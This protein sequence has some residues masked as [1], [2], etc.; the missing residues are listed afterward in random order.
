MR[1]PC[2]VQCSCTAGSSGGNVRTRNWLLWLLPLGTAC[3][4]GLE[5]EDLGTE[6]EA[7]TTTCGGNQQTY[8]DLYKPPPGS[9][10]ACC[11]PYGP[12]YFS[13]C[14]PSGTLCC[15]GTET[16]QIHCCDSTRYCRIRVN[17]P[18]L[19]DAQC[20]VAI[21]GGQPFNGLTQ[22][23]APRGV[24]VAKKPIA[25]LADC[26]DRI[27][28]PGFDAVPN[29]CGTVEKRLP[30]HFGPANFTPQCNAHDICYVTCP[31]PKRKCD[32]ALLKGI[33][34]T[35]DAAF[36]NLSQLL[37]KVTCEHVAFLAAK[38]AVESPIGVLAYDSAQ[39]RGCQCCL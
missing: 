30:D 28:T 3:G 36:T 12:L 4:V 27:S 2:G 5:K 17:Q 25:S 1:P 31:N 37:D 13:N 20:L 33:N 8:C 10:K 19:F 39:K 9:T 26:P 6:A 22:C 24:P 34:D 16:T 18:D 7:L 15:P 38:T 14:C 23:C 32:D 21:C 29:G 11:V 35:C